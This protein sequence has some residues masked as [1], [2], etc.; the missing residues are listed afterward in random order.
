MLRL[1]RAVATC[2]NRTLSNSL[3]ETWVNE[4]RNYIIENKNDVRF[5][6][7]VWLTI[8][9]TASRTNDTELQQISVEQFTKR[10]NFESL[11]TKVEADEDLQ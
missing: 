5:D 8:C 4:F 11:K 1:Y 6:H 9:D 3:R 7:N 2:D 10:F